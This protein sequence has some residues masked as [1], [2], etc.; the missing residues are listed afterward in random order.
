MDQIPLPPLPALFSLKVCKFAVFHSSFPSIPL[1][2]HSFSHCRLCYSAIDLVWLKL[3]EA[4]Q[5][6]RKASESSLWFVFPV[7]DWVRP[8]C[9]TACWR[10]CTL[11]W[12]CQPVHTHSCSTSWCLLL[13]AE[14]L[15][16]A[17]SGLL[18]QDVTKQRHWSL[19][20]LVK[21][22]CDWANSTKD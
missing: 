2:S 14:Q 19:Q 21:Y 12:H 8:E 18:Q 22:D 15:T 9:H 1:F 5:L 3:P 17:T 6:P 16:K 7:W 13:D 20:N 4:D 10:W 11:P